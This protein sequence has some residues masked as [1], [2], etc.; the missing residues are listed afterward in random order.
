MNNAGKELFDKVQKS[1]MQIGKQG[2]ENAI[3]IRD[4]VIFKRNFAGKE[5]PGKRKDGSKFVKRGRTF[6]LALTEE[7]MNEIIKIK[8]DCKWNSWQ[9]GGPEDPDLVLYSIEVKIN[10]D[11][12]YPPRVTLYTS[13]NGETN[14]EVL[15]AEKVGI[16]DEISFERADVEINPYDPDDTGKFTAYLSKMNIKQK[17]HYDD[18]FNNGW[19]E[20]N[21]Y[22]PSDVNPFE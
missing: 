19:E 4:A 3:I 20:H 15:N 16:L 6:S 8:G 21:P 18:E 13:W 12:Q 1:K 17:N 9:F 10:M 2:N 5:I 11:S 14:A 7:M 22:T